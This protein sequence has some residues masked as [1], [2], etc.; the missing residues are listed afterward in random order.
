MTFPPAD[1]PT[2]AFQ[3]APGA[4]SEE[5]LLER[6]RWRAAPLPCRS[7]G[8]VVDAVEE[9]RADFGVLPVENTLAGTVTGAYDALAGS[10]LLVVGEVIHPIRH[11][12]LGLA[13]ARPDRLT[14]IVSHPVALA[15]CT[16]FLSA[17]PSAESVAVYDTAGGAEEV[18]ERGDPRTGAV[19]SRGAAARYGLEILAEG[20][21]DR[22]DNQTRFYVVR[23]R[24]GEPSGASGTASEPVE[25]GEH[26]TVLLL[27]VEDRPGSL[28][29]VLDSFARRGINLT[30]LESRPAE[31]PWRYRFLLEVAADARDPGAVDALGEVRGRSS[32]FRNLGSFPAAPRG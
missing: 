16:R 30:K 5:A 21:Q 12:L 6:F 28:L 10:R 18:A 9:G 3:G 14:R 8:A 1:V 25:A 4:F 26:R 31:R 27:E 7:F 11:C 13:G 23:R 29:S 24:T 2:V 32:T 20:I 19:A 22:D 17:H 15:Q